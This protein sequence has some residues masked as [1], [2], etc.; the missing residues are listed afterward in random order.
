MRTWAPPKSGGQDGIQA[1]STGATPVFLRLI[2]SYTIKSP[3]SGP[4]TSFWI[5]SPVIIRWI[6]INTYICR[7]FKDIL[8]INKNILQAKPTPIP[9]SVYRQYFITKYCCSL[10]SSPSSMHVLRKMHYQHKAD[11]AI[12][13]A[14]QPQSLLE[15]FGLLLSKSTSFKF[16]SC[17]GQPISQ[18]LLTHIF[19]I[20]QLLK[21]GQL[22]S[23]QFWNIICLNF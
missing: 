21:S 18:F 19:Q 6:A 3:D 20:H 13:S 8:S 11:C 23:N 5:E 1:A 16:H 7:C 22:T 15:L 2:D 17:A 4:G 12:L 10:H 9:R 14:H